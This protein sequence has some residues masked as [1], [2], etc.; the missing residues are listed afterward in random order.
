MTVWTRYIDDVWMRYI[1]DVW[2]RY[3][4]DVWMRYIDDVFFIWNNDETSLKQYIKF[5]D[6]YSDEKKMKFKIKFESN[7][8][9]ESVNFLDV[10]NS[11]KTVVN[12]NN[13]A[14]VDIKQGVNCKTTE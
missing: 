11:N 8:S 6:N 5:C 1:D 10:M 3:I 7:I 13:G 2:M 14:K 9:K 12:K 4:D